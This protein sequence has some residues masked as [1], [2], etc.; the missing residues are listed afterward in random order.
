MVGWPEKALVG[1]FIGG[2]KD[3]IAAEIKML[4]PE[5]INAAIK[6]ARMQDKKLQRTRITGPPNRPHPPAPLDHT[7][8]RKP[9]NS[10]AHVA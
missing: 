10:K 4:K 7:Q 3:E 1:C 9:T 6:L 2:L 8:Q 5:N